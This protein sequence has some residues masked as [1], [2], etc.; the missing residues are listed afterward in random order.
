M[1]NI[2]Y[3]M[4]IIK[5]EKTDSFKIQFVQRFLR[6][7][8]AKYVILVSIGFDSSPPK[9]LSSGLLNCLRR[10]STFSSL[11]ILYD[12]SFNKYPAGLLGFRDAACKP[13]RLLAPG[14]QGRRHFPPDGHAAW[15]LVLILFSP[16]LFISFHVLRH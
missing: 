3:F 16:Q 5:L 14:L 7:L 8:P 10:V 11:F 6:V 2:R 9:P 1:E 4:I 13:Q 12:S 15:A